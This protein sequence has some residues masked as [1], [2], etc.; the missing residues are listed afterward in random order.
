MFN[1]FAFSIARI[2]SALLCVYVNIAIRM[3]I[4]YGEIV[5]VF[6]VVIVG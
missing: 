4:T 5:S 2:C 1:T 6:S 3:N